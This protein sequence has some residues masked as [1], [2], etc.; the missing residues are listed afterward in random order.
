MMPLL[1]KLSENDKRLI[2]VLLLVFIL[3]FVIAGYVGLL[4]KKIMHRQGRRAD[5][6]VHDVVVS[7]VVSTKGKLFR[8]GE[9]KNARILTRQ[10][11]LPF[12]IMLVAALT[13]VIYLAATDKWGM[14]LLAYE[15]DSGG[16]STI[17]FLWDWENAPRETF[18]GM[19]LIS[20]WPALLNSPH[21]DAPSIPAYIFFVGM[22]VGGVWFL[23]AV[24]A[25]IARSYRLVR[26]TGKVFTKSL[27]NYDPGQQM[28]HIKDE[29]NSESKPGK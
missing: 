21:F 23:V 10:A 3:V 26:L 16:F 14:D 6:M 7:G 22:I 5:D 29:I 25:Y 4:V 20:D 13:I 9:R 19:E 15:K 28:P 24:Q 11:W 2:V 18:F 17:L 1:A 8:F 27:E 12:L